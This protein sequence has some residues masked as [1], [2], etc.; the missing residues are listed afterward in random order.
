M[1]PRG[2]ANESIDTMTQRS[3]E[4]TGVRENTNLGAGRA[5]SV[6]VVL[7]AVAVVLG[8]FVLASPST[9]SDDGRAIESDHDVAEVVEQSSGAS[10]EGIDTDVLNSASD[11]TQPD[12]LA[13]RSIPGNEAL[14]L[15]SPSGSLPSPSFN[16]GLPTGEWHLTEKDESILLRG[17]EDDVSL[18]VDLPLG[19]TVNGSAEL[20]INPTPS[21]TIREDAAF[22]VEVDGLPRTT[23]SSGDGDILLDLAPD[24]FDEA[25][26]IRVASTT[27]IVG[28]VDCL[29]PRH[30][31][32]WIDVGSPVIRLPIAVD[33]LDVA[34]T[35]MGV[36]RVS[37]VTGEAITVQ[38]ADPES[39]AQ[40]EVAGHLVA[41][42]SQHDQPADWR[43]VGGEAVVEPGAAFLVSTG[44]RDGTVSVVVEAGRPIVRLDG[45]PDEILAIARSLADT[46]SLLFFDRPEVRADEL[47]AQVPAS[48]G[49]VYTFSGSG[50]DDRTI[51]GFGEKSLVYRI[52]VPAGI[53]ADSASVAL[54]ATH[55]PTMANF[56]ATITVKING[57][58][59]EVVAIADAAG[60]ID[61]LHTIT[62]AD[63][64]PGLNFVTVDAQLGS[65]SPNTCEVG[66][67][68]WFTVSSA[69][70][71]GV[72]RPDQPVPVEI[73]VEDA[74]FALAADVDFRAT[75][76]VVADSPDAHEVEVAFDV[77]SELAYRSEGG[78]P[79]LVTDSGADTNR[80]L[81]V[82]GTDP[83]R[84]LLIDIPYLD[85]SSS[86]GVV[87]AVASPYAD[88]RVFLAFASRTD[89]GLAR[90]VDAGLSSEMNG[91]ATHYALVSDIGTRPIDSD[92][93]EH[94]NDPS[95]APPSGLAFGDEGRIVGPAADEYEDWIVSQ[96]D[97]IEAA[98]APE[99]SQR[100]A[101][102][103]G[104][105]LVVMSLASVWWLRQLRSNDD[106]E[107]GH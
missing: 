52:H 106:V 63:L 17:Y 13:A 85:G 54:F 10:S 82:V 68:G 28:D 61:V 86:V 47:P 96:A 70:G 14:S 103:L 11:G 59:E 66:L 76:I 88:G 75:D 71:V 65:E 36:G 73:G 53:P 12:Q 3:D 72:H 81:V 41:A 16:V 8:L 18:D 46:N 87:S 35:L 62:P 58:T 42:V 107:A 57:S 60:E 40:L 39:P 23:W 50:Y 74:R 19:W 30:V 51:R 97:R 33:E 55:A 69:S 1:H 7:V 26:E 95:D 102:A 80:H 98:R 38:L 67:P 24:L 2:S 94:F 6:Y 22:V 43:L 84:P 100:R 79:R 104:I 91:V 64:R 4:G 20:A 29:D 37:Q 31:A 44:D 56:E 48:Y 77:I 49:E 99:T 9:G 105:G 83:A 101:I 45:R 27:P 25:F 78:S 92:V 34:R 32:R 90:A 89:E 21:G 15:S 93:I 5:H